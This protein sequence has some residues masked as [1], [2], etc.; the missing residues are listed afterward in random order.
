MTFVPRQLEYLSTLTIQNFS[1]SLKQI[2][3]KNVAIPGEDLNEFDI[4]LLLLSPLASKLVCILGEKELPG[5]N[6]G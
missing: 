6:E 1:Q 3:H 2:T 4:D 5:E